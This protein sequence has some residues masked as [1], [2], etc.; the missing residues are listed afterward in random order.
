MDKKKVKVVKNL[1]LPTAI[2]KLRGFLGYVGFYRRF[3][4]GFYT[5]SKSLTHL[6]FKGVDFVLE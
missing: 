1:P 4:K 5:T 6:L 3:I 2:K